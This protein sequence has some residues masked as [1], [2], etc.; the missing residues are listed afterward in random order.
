MIWNILGRFRRLYSR[1]RCSTTLVVRYCFKTQ[2]WISL[3]GDNKPSSYCWRA[4]HWNCS[5]G[6]FSI[7]S[8]GE[9]ECV[10]PQTKCA[11]NFCRC[12]ER[13]ALLIFLVWPSIYKYGTI[14]CFGRKV[15]RK[16]SNDK[17]ACSHHWPHN[18]PSLSCRWVTT[19]S[20]SNIYIEPTDDWGANQPSDLLL[21]QDI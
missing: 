2:T 4:S 3:P 16:H 17:Y 12:L 15:D 14:S 10:F 7:R 18:S 13:P 19:G 11:S 6:K 9:G 20:Q 8:V 21:A 5:C 1:Q